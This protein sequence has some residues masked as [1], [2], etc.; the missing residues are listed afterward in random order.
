MVQ[1]LAATGSREIDRPNPNQRMSAAQGKNAAC[2]F[3]MAKVMTQAGCGTAC[4]LRGPLKRAS[5]H[6]GFCGSLK[7]EAPQLTGPKVANKHP[8]PSAEWEKHRLCPD[9][10]LLLSCGLLATWLSITST[11]GSSHAHNLSMART[12]LCKTHLGRPIC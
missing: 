12:E 9:S 8:C 11:H 1:G 4:E 5:S 3:R 2:P 10:P 6:L 7:R